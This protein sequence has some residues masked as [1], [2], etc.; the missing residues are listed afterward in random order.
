MMRQM[1]PTATESPVV[2]AIRTSFLF[3]LKRYGNSRRLGWGTGQQTILF[4]PIWQIV[5]F[6][7]G[8]RAGVNVIGR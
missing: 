1:L 8:L 7:V 2:R 4:L 6:G 3:I 5:H